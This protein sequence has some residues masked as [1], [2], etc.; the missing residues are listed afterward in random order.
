MKYGFDLDGTLDR[1]RVLLLAKQLLALGNE[2]HIIS[3]VFDESGDWQSN[4]AKTA[5]VERLWGGEIPLGVTL[6]VIHSA[7][8]PDRQ[9]RLVNIGLQKGVLCEQ[10]GID[11]MFDDSE[12]YTNVMKA[13]AGD[14]I[15]CHVR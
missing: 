2:I 14:L 6:H 7:D 10:L 15:V 8:H 12:T 13:M 11:V 4:D 5:K 9:Y 1:K 3:G